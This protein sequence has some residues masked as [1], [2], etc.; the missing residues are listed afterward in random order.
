VATD[1]SMDELIGL[2]RRIESSGAQLARWWFPERRAAFEA[3]LLNDSG[4]S[5]YYF[6]SELEH[7]QEHYGRLPGAELTRRYLVWGVFVRD[8]LRQTRQ[9]VL[10]ARKSMLTVLDSPTARILPRCFP[11]SSK[12]RGSDEV[13]VLRRWGQKPELKDFFEWRDVIV[14]AECFTDELEMYFLSLNGEAVEPLAIPPRAV[15]VRK[16]PAYFFDNA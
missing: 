12:W 2:L 15:P 1:R 13:K 4:Y 11:G 5:E 8:Q 7:F 3:A 16:R 6:D 9:L 14:E 10:Q